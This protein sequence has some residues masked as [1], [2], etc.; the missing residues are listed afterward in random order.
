M[1]TEGRHSEDC[2]I[3]I[4]EL[5]LGNPIRAQAPEWKALLAPPRHSLMP[6]GRNFQYKVNRLL[7]EVCDLAVDNSSCR[8]CSLSARIRARKV[9]G[10]LDV[11][12]AD[13]ICEVSE[14]P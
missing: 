4:I 1:C 11:T 7:V 2:S 3:G 10:C 13:V 6:S 9:R 5:N 12:F 8:R 14:T